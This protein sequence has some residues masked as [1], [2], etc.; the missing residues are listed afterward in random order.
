MNQHKF[1]FII[2]ANQER[3]L[4]ECLRYIGN[5]RVPE[6]YEKETVVIRGAKS[7]TSGY[8]QA[9]QQTDAK[10]K[11]YMHQDVL[12][13]NQDLLPELLS[14]FQSASVGMVGIIGKKEFM[15]SAE[16][17]RNWDAGA[18]EVFNG[19]DAGFFNFSPEAAE[20]WLDV[21]AAD[22]VMIA[23]QYDLPWDEEFDGW[24][25]YDISQSE[26]F[27]EAG[28]RIVVPCVEKAEDV[29]AFHDAG[30][31]EYDMWEK[32]REKFCRKYSAKGY[33]YVR[34]PFIKNRSERR[35]KQSRVMA[36]FGRQDFDEAGRL[37]M[38]CESGDLN[39]QMAY[40]VCY[41][42][43]RGEEMMAYNRILSGSLQEP[44]TFPDAYDEVKFMLRRF[45][46]GQADG[47]WEVLR[48]KLHEGKI[49]M[50][51]LWVVSH[52]CV[53]DSN[54]LWWRVF[55]RYEEEIRSLVMQGEIIEAE[56]LLLQLDEKWRGKDGNILL[57]LIQ[58]FRREVEK[59]VQRGVFDYSLDPDELTRHFIRLKY[60]LR[61]VEFGLPERYQ[62]EA[63]E[64]CE[65]TGVSDY[66]ILRILQNNI[67][68]KE[69][70]CRNLARIFA[71]E[72][73]SGSMR[74]GLYTQ[75]AESERKK[76]E[77]SNE[78]P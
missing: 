15:Q 41:L 65:Q 26:R 16:Y 29:W 22:G 24:D 3:Y 73:G 64:Y 10:Y 23:T 74:A 59:G 6:G 20:G 69:Q 70:F 68:Y 67:F 43:I 33:Q 30:Q 12:L 31:C 25:F 49:S 44:D 5:L 55:A 35:E 60:Y 72:E 2:C 75:L 38:Q 76:K 57:I 78:Q 45:Y 62:R 37:L 39:S 19:T 54:R 32:Y 17:S 77:V 9:M 42:V 11:I 8:N 66:L 13:V 21:A 51:F 14:V 1:C 47:A 34:S 63:Y 36:A 53:A 40:V 46:F 71:E 18:A 4:E 58:V 61:R 27:R 7:M 56:K 52:E 50:K 28:Y 48:E